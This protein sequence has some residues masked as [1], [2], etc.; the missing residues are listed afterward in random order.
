[1]SVFALFQIKC[2]FQ[3]MQTKHPFSCF[4]PL[5]VRTSC[6]LLGGTRIKKNKKTKCKQL[7]W[8]WQACCLALWG[9]W[10]THFCFKSLAVCVSSGY[11]WVLWAGSWPR[12]G[13]Q[14][15]A[16]KEGGTVFMLASLLCPGCLESSK[17]REREGKMRIQS[18]GLYFVS[19]SCLHHL[20]N[21]IWL[22]IF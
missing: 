21:I 6:E 8:A 19:L 9:V 17:K 1:M 3:F 20:F 2:L 11:I 14:G 7:T 12:V 13:G 10:F 18:S 5:K 22:K 16:V 4:I 15:R